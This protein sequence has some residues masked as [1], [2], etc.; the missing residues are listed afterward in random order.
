MTS[1][2]PKE[3][4]SGCLILDIPGI[5]PPSGSLSLECC[6]LTETER[7]ESANTEVS[8][9]ALSLEVVTLFSRA[10]GAA[11]VCDSA[12]CECLCF[13]ERFSERERLSLFFTNF[14]WEGWEG[15]LLPPLPRVSLLELGSGETP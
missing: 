7:E 15:G 13:P 2:V 12:D 4:S 14:D 8:G 5:P 1:F 11:R 6:F 3:T 10:F 9:E